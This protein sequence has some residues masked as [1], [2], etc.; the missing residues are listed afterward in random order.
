MLGEDG[1]SFLTTTLGPL[2]PLCELEEGQRPRVPSVGNDAGCDTYDGEARF[3]SEGELLEAEPSWVGASMRGGVESEGAAV[4]EGKVGQLGGLG[5][6]FMW[7]DVKGAAVAGATAVDMAR[8][9]RG[10]SRLD[11]AIL[12]VEEL[13]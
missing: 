12:G 13:K 9:R 4:E 5:S 11:R 10:R 6:R 3:L 2:F 7:E 8:D 1:G